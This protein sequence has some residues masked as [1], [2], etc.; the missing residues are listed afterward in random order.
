MPFAEHPAGTEACDDVS[1]MSKTASVSFRERNLWAFDVSL[2]ILLAELINVINDLGPDQCPL[3]LV[4]LVPD[5]RVHAV[6]GADFHLDL[7]LGLTDQQRR[8]LLALTAEACRRLHERET[9]TA[10]EAASWVV[11]AGLESAS[12]EAGE[13]LEGRDH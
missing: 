5:L 6:V 11:V 10:A 9:I 4:D 2:S 13:D 1:A 8:H 7:D 3:W 12:A